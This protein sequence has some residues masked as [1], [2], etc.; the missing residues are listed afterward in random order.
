M[1]LE[2]FLRTEI[3]IGRENLEKLQTKRVIIFG[4]GGVGSY[5]IEALGRC[6]IGEIHIVD[7]DCISKSNINRQLLAL[8]STLGKSKVEIMKL[9]LEDI[10]PTIKVITYESFFSNDTL[11][12]FSLEDFDYVLDAIDSLNPK[13]TLLEHTLKKKCPLISSM[14]A[15]G[16]LDPTAIRIGNLIDVINDKLASSVRKRLRRRGLEPNYVVIY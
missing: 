11:E 8:E 10:N 15:G 1:N 9:R 14:G 6:A 4:L 7:F 3:L 12:D 16:R 13:V 2:R 5:A